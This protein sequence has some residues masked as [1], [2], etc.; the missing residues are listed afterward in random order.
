M[1]LTKTRCGSTTTDEVA[2]KWVAKGAA[3]DVDS[4]S[5]LSTAASSVRRPSKSSERSDLSEFLAPGST[6]RCRSRS[7]GGCRVRVIEQTW[8]I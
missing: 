8:S 3:A 1:S 6:S 7:R 5:D 2:V 4:D